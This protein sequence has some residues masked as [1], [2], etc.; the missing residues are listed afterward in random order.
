MSLAFS[1]ITQKDRVLVLETPLGEEVLLLERCAGSDTISGMFSFELDLL[2]DVQRQQDAAVV[3]DKIVGHVPLLTP[4]T[5]R[6]PTNSMAPGFSSTAIRS[7]MPRITSILQVSSPPSGAF[8]SEGLGEGRSSRIRRSF[9]V[10]MRGSV[11]T[12]PSLPLSTCR[13]KRRVV[14][15]FVSHPG[16]TRALP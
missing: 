6:V 4:S 12:S 5:S 14:A 8:S 10:P 2:A 15:C 11:R 3:A 1:P 7:S 9:S 13:R 16:P